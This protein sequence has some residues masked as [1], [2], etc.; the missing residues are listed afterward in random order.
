MK[1]KKVLLISLLSAAL[2][3]TSACNLLGSKGGGKKKKSSSASTSTSQ[4]EPVSDKVAR[5]KVDAKEQVVVGDTLDLD[6]MVHLYNGDNKE[7]D[8]K[9]YEIEVP[10][11]SQSLVSVDGHKVSFL[12]EGSVNLNIKSGDVSAKFSTNCLSALKKQF[13]EETATISN[14]YAIWGIDENEQL[15][16]EAIH[17][18]DYVACEYF[19]QDQAGEW[20]S[21]GLMIPNGPKT[22][23]N[24]VYSYT[25]DNDEWSSITV[26]PAPEASA[27]DFGN[28]FVCMPFGI[29]ILLFETKTGQ[30]TQGN[31]Y[32]YLYLSSSV[33]SPSYSRY[34]DSYVSEICY[35]SIGVTYGG[36]YDFDCLKIYK[37]TFVEGMERFLLTFDI[38]NTS[39]GVYAGSE[40]MFLI[41]SSDTAYYGA[42][43][44]RNYIDTNQEP[45]TLDYAP[46]KE[47]ISTVTAAHNYTVDV[48]GHEYE[49]EQTS[50]GYV[51]KSTEYSY[52]EQV[53]ANEGQY[54]DTIRKEGETAIEAASG[55]VEHEGSLY[56]YTYA[57]ESYPATLVGAGQKV[58]VEGLNSTLS[59]LGIESH[60][61]NFF[62]SKIE[63]VTGGTRYYTVLY[64]TKSFWQ[65]FL[66][67]LY[68]GTPIINV[69]NAMMQQY[70]D[71]VFTDSYC[72]TYI[73]VLEDTT[74]L[75]FDMLIRFSD[76]TLQWDCEA[77]FKNVGT[78]AAITTDVVY[79][80]QKLDFLNQGLLR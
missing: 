64:F 58:Y 41:Y 53:L 12:K 62:V 17:A 11:A 46:L 42:A 67:N 75:H 77:T 31:D 74:V 49:L 50:S 35:R 13:I 4:V 16:A 69:V 48:V 65:S 20:L 68:C 56:S 25:F 27:S 33:K 3:A 79:P 66:G 55:L 43:P 24:L 5:I 22:Q 38:I 44:V 21:G 37:E 32:D 72:T 51:V 54:E 29:D 1:T 36:T 15:Y 70:Q 9:E 28:F 63:E 52:V 39:T 7:I 8:S 10:A 19:D 30:D 57:S 76:G 6:S 73:D 34:F 80:S 45:E 47:H 2:V 40:Y 59:S 78:T 14:N 23:R 71:D 18:D 61:S 60:W 26:N